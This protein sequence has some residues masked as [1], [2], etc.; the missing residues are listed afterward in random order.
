MRATALVAQNFWFAYFDLAQF[1]N[2]R[3]ADKFFVAGYLAAAFASEA[4]I[5]ARSTNVQTS[6]GAFSMSALGQKETMAALFNDLIG[7]VQ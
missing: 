6:I 2:R 7:S 5:E 3:E 1:S 4:E